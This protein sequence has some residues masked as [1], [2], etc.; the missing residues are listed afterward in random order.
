MAVCE[1]NSLKWINV[2]RLIGAGNRKAISA[3]V[4]V[5]AARWWGMIQASSRGMSSISAPR[6]SNSA[7]L[8]GEANNAKVCPRV[9][10]PKIVRK[11]YQ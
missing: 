8:S 3:S 11:K 10:V 5:K 2:R 7:W 6:D 9:E 4:K 1:R